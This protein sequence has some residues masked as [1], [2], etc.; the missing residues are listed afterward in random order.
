MGDWFSHTKWTLPFA[1]F[2]VIFQVFKLVDKHTSKEGRE[3]LAEFLRRFA[4]EHYLGSLPDIIQSTFNHIF[5]EKHF[6][7]RCVTASIVLSIVSLIMTFIISILYD[8][9]PLIAAGIFI[10]KS[11]ELLK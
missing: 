4:Y 10:Q 1:T 8:V 2:A 5:G 3:S 6:S 9:R 11:M 7:V